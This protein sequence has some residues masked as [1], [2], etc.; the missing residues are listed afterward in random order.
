MAS[1]A[2][3]PI[4]KWL[5]NKYVS[6]YVEELDTRQ[7]MV[8]LFKGEVELNN[9]TLR[10]DA[11][12]QMH[13]PFIV[14]A[15]RVQNLKIV[16]PLAHLGSKPVRVE[17]D[18]I[19]LMAARKDEL[20]MAYDAATVAEKALLKK[21]KQLA[22]IDEVALA[23]AKAE[24]GAEEEADADAGDAGYWEKLKNKIIDNLQLKITNVHVRYEDP[25]NGVAAGLSFEK[26]ELMSTNGQWLPHF[27]VG[28]PIV[29]KLAVLQ[30]LCVYVDMGTGVEQPVMLGARLERMGDAL[31]AD[32]DVRVRRAGVDSAA[33]YEYVL[34]PVDGRIQIKFSKSEVLDPERVSARIE[35]EA[36]IGKISLTLMRKQYCAAM[37]IVDYAS[38]ISR[39][40]KYLKY[41]PGRAI[42]EQASDGTRKVRDQCRAERRR[43]LGACRR[44]IDAANPTAYVYEY[45]RR[46]AGEGQVR[47][48]QP[49]LLLSRKDDA[50][51]EKLYSIASSRV[52]VSVADMQKLDALEMIE[53]GLRTDAGAPPPPAARLWWKFA[54]DT[55]CHDGRERVK[56]AKRRAWVMGK[57]NAYSDNYLKTLRVTDGVLGGLNRKNARA[58][59]ALEEDERMLMSD[60][61]YLRSLV[62]AQLDEIAKAHP[63]MKAKLGDRSVFARAVRRVGWRHDE[64]EEEEEETSG[65]RRGRS[66]SKG[67]GR[68]RSSVGRSRSGTQ[69]GGGVWGYMTG[70]WGGGEDGA[71]DAAADG[72]ATKDS[73]SD[74]S[75]SLSDDQK[76]HLYRMIDYDPGPFHLLWSVVAR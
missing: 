50:L 40:A 17:I 67:R 74:V 52:D 24:G 39:H 54:L 38:K 7:L 56:E 4:V 75:F 16:C 8:N 73:A 60:V 6:Q 36:V 43:L 76:S 5:L 31:I 9:L 44:K 42:L 65:R 13:L 53:A 28:L 18:G 26:I 61:M 14:R 71:S 47:S 46:D 57:R 15:G 12:E 23:R 19:Y 58:L 20:G 63:E 2:L 45:V 64:E 32:P 51:K 69:S 25:R 33:G 21:R 1:V 59:I 48:V 70:W 35:A 3:T 10:P 55:I 62:D 49:L 29:H 72:S 41:R 11:L 30:R 68:K 37:T 66:K 34:H 27:V 22:L